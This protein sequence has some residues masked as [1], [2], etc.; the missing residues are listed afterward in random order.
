[1]RTLLYILL[2]I[3]VFLSG[4]SGSGRVDRHLDELDRIMAVDP[5]K[6]GQIFNDIDTAG[7]SENQKNRLYLLA[8]YYTVIYANPIDLSEA[9]IEGFD[10]L[11][12]GKFNADEI[13]WSIIKSYDAKLKGNPVARLENLKDAEFL[14][15]Q[16][17]RKPELGFIYL[18]L[19][20]VYAQ[21]F[22]ATVSR[23]YADKAANIFR[24]LNCP[25]HLRDARMAAVGAIIV[26][27]DYKTALD[28]LEAMYSDVMAISTDSY[29]TYFLDQLAR[30]YSE[31]GKTDKAAEIWHNLYDGR[32]ISANTLAHW[33]AAYLSI[34]KLDSA[35]LLIEKANSLPHNATDEYLCRNV[36]YQIN[37]K[38][39]RKDKLPA[40]DDLRQ[41]AAIKIGE[42]RKLEESSLTLNIKYD[43]ETRRA[44]VEANSA[45]FHTLVVIFVAVTLILAAII[46]LL[47]LRKRNRLLKLE[48]ENDMLRIQSL[49]NNLFESD[50]RNKDINTRITELFQSRFKLLDGLATTYFECKDTGQEQKRIYCDVKGALKNLSSPE[51]IRE[52]TDILNGYHDNVMD[53]F[54]ADFPKLSDAQYRLA[55]YLF[56]GFS[57]P[58]I[59]IFTGTE[60]RNIY[61]YKSRLKSLISKS[62][63]PRKTEYLGYFR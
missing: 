45:K 44:W 41:A 12:S 25:I 42:E 49:Q 54:N 13:K 62:E 59:S 21:G 3:P 17:D 37:E 4:C 23:Y 9:D 50:S 2:I 19:S 14:S 1:M 8:A 39:G 31:N 5:E 34:N 26:Q 11:F 30:I 33:A 51:A 35:L 16:L 24:E 60:L 20:N 29:K 10:S 46:V 22:N 56:C 18:Y 7:L 28:S 40:I 43:S 61:V 53:R 15:I 6:A 57:L 55:L 63:S 58:S 48:H 36:E 27:R 47:L 32:E 38:L 52:L